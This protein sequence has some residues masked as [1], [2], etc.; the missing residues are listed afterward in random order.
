MRVWL[1]A[2]FS[3][4]CVVVAVPASAAHPTWT[5][6]EQAVAAADTAFSAAS[7]EK[8]GHAWADFA[9]DS[10]STQ[11]GHGKAEIGA[12]YDKIYARPG[13]SLSWHPTFVKIVGDVG[14]TSGPYELHQ[15]DAQGQDRRST[16]KYVTVWQRQADGEWRFVW[17]GGTPD[18]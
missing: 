4:V 16:G 14:I 12:A 9:D 11:V 2:T 10:A 8:H 13:V 18:K 6:D 15:A 17:D 7:R 3:I 5:A 1:A